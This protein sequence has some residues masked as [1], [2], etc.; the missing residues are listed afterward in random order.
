LM[1]ELTLNHIKGSCKYDTKCD[2]KFDDF[3][4]L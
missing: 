4:Y 2:A 1:S 3:V